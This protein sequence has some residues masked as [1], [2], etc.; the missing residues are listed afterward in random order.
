MANSLSRTLTLRPRRLSLLARLRAA[1]DSQRQ[2]R[3]L[4]DLSDAQLED[5]GISR[6]EAEAEAQRRLWDAPQ[7]WLREAR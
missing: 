3:Q 7:Q 5:I 2:R 4:R 1:F 6:T